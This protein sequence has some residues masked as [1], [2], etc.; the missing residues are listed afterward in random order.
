MGQRLE[1]ARLMGTD[2]KDGHF[3]WEE[4]TAAYSAAFQ[5]YGLDVDELAPQGAAAQIRA[6]PIHRQLV[7]A[8]DNWANLRRNLQVRGWRELLAVARAADPD[9]WRNRLRAL[10]EEADEAK[11]QALSDLAASARVGEWPLSTLVL[12]G[13]LSAGTDASERVAVLLEQARQLHPGDFWINTVLAQLLEESHPPR[14]DEA[15]R[16]RTAAAAVRPRSCGAHSYLGNALYHKGRLDEAIA[17]YH[18]ALRLKGDF[19]MAHNN[20]G[21]ALLDKGQL[22]EAIAEFREAIRV[23]NDYAPAHYN[24]GNALTS[25]VL[26]D[27][28]IAEY[29]ETIRLKKDYAEAYCNLGQGLQ[30]QGH[31]AEALTEL[32]RGHDLGSRKP[33]WSYPSATWIR[34]AEHLAELEARLPQ[35]LKGDSRP[36][37]AHDCQDL[38]LLCACKHL[39]AASARWYG[40]AFA[41]RPALADDLSSQP[42]YSAAGAAALAGCGQGKDADHLD[43][44]ERARLRKL[45]LDWLR[46]DLEAWG[47]LLDNKPALASR[48]AKERLLHWLHDTDFAGV[49]GTAALARLPE[50]ERGDWQL[51]WQEVEALRQRAARPPEK[52]AATRP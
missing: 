19:P 33:D 22:D 30:T 27:E 52:E 2:V 7:A 36:V 48:A 6:R 46:V 29:R 31:F 18:E 41:A 11:A 9:P 5:E 16:F 37:D 23:K 38:G 32:K 10:L 45:A 28:A 40:E 20:L 3:D 35:L 51:L 50:A 21:A 34:E 25:K 8:L 12:L 13:A 1:E 15:I 24:L 43:D 17:E 44:K 39:S 47:R 26:L 14:P 42:R 4:T 49:R